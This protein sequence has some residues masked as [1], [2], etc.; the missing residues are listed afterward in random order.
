MWE[1]GSEGWDLG[2]QTR[3]QGPQAKGS[4]SAVFFFE[5]SGIRLYFFVGSE[6]GICHAFGIKDRKFVYKNGISDKKQTNKQTN[7]NK[8]KKKKQKKHAPL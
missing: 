3:D 4:G 8:T 6:T 2:T 5:A 1:Q 7:K